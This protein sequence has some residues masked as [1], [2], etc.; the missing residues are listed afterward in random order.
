MVGADSPV[1]AFIRVSA[2]DRDE[3]AD[4]ADGRFSYTLVVDTREMQLAPRQC[5]A[6]YVP[7]GSYRRTTAVETLIRPKD[8]PYCN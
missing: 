7:G 5:P 8:E 6:V 2:S 4:R 1:G 3:L